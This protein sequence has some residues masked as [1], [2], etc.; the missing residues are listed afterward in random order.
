MGDVMKENKTTTIFIA[1][2]MAFLCG[3]A[4]FLSCRPAKN[5]GRPKKIILAVDFSDMFSAPVLIAENL[6]YFKDEGIEV[7]IKEYPSGRTALADMISKKNLDVV[8][9]AQTPVMYNSFSNDSYSILAGMACSYEA[10]SIML[11]RKD[12]GINTALDL[13]GRRIGTPVG[14]TGHFFLNLFLM[15]HGLK[16]SDV[17]IVDFDAPDLPKA[18]ADGVVDAIAVW[19]PQIFNAQKLL[20]SKAII[21][22]NKNIYRV[23]F[24]LVSD[25]DFLRQ[26]ADA[27]KGLLKAIDKAEDFIMKN[28]EQSVSIVAN[29]LKM[30]REI[31]AAIWDQYQFRIFL[32][33]AILTDLEAEGR[34]AMENKYANVK[35]L[36]DYSRFIFPDILEKVKPVSVN[37]I[38]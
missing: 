34:W 29:R 7:E 30:D 12:K 22:Q 17:E 11:A 26:N 16:I 27:L 36:P 35:T 3:A 14:S 9:C 28:R 37:L 8:T 5:A 32:D 33:Q 4:L 15:Y 18:L 2:A 10:G 19:Q 23:D 38:R 24:Y 13:K 6:G 21:L 1:T 25:K 20:G 31:T